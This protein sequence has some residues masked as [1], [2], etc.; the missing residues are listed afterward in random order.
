MKGASDEGVG[1]FVFVGVTA[2]GDYYLHGSHNQKRA[3][4]LWLLEQGLDLTKYS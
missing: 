3:E 2:D 1:K 4:I